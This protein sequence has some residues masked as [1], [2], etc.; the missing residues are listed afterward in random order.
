METPGEIAETQEV[1]SAQV[2]NT[3]PVLSQQQ[4]LEALKSSPEILSAIKN[5]VKEELKAEN[6]GEKIKESRRKY[7]FE[8]DGV[9]VRKSEPRKYKYRI[10]MEDAVEKAVVKCDT[11]GRPISDIN[12]NTGK[13]INEHKVRITFHDG[14]ET[15]MDLIEYLQRSYYGGE[16]RDWEYVQYDDIKVLPNGTREFTFRTKQFGVFTVHQNYLG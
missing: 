16:A 11:I 8:E 15:T 5:V 13:R 7:G 4:I 14:S 2:E 12:H 1:Q 3:P 9:T 10:L 6:P